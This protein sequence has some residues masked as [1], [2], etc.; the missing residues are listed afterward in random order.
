LPPEFL[1]Q[2]DGT[3]YSFKDNRV[4]FSP[5]GT[6]EVPVAS[7]EGGQF[8][9]SVNGQE[10]AVDPKL[11]T[12]PEAKWFLNGESDQIMAVNGE[13][14]TYWQ[15]EF[16]LTTN[17]WVEKTLP[18]EVSTNVDYPTPI[19][20]N[21]IISNRWATAV[22]RDI[23]SGKIPTFGPDVVVSPMGLSP[24]IYDTYGFNGPDF[25]ESHAFYRTKP[26][27]RPIMYSAYA[28]MLIDGWPHKI[29][30][31]QIAENGGGY[32][33][34]NIIEPISGWLQNHVVDNSAWVGP[35]T[36][37]KSN[38]CDGASMCLWSANIGNEIAAGAVDKWV[39]Q[40]IVDDPILGKVIFDCGGSRWY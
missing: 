8:V 27:T 24:N 25:E 37:L 32:G 38:L 21:D 13:S 3:V 11:A 15:Y 29:L 17:Q 26:E 5:D 36:K 23:D 6:R 28:E 22:R 2:F 7:I 39:S 40:G 18:Q 16:D 30:T 34:V 12:V 4:L 35:T 19:E 1:A 14:G 20:W 33:L 10:V 9:F 31:E